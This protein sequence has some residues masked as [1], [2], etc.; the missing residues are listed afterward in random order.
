L[1]ALCL[2]CDGIYSPPDLDNNDKPKTKDILNPE[3][4]I[5]DNKKHQTFLVNLG[6]YNTELFQTKIYEFIV[7]GFFD[8]DFDNIAFKYNK[9]FERGTKQNSFREARE[10]SF[11]GSFDNNGDDVVKKIYNEFINGIEVLTPSDFQGTHRLLSDYDDGDERANKIL[12]LYFETHKDNKDM[13]E[14]PFINNQKIKDFFKESL[15]RIWNLNPP[16]LEEAVEIFIK[17]NN[18]P[19]INK[20]LN[21]VKED[22]FC[23]LFKESKI[24]NSYKLDISRKFDNA[25]L[26]IQ[27]IKK[28]SKINKLRIEYLSG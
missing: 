13:L 16:S 28:E 10:V 11:H 27:K 14:S 19:L 2:F 5:Y 26:A 18:D 8:S 21:E 24:H 12:E 7:N 9:K 17:N 22:D 1:I 15:E 25:K 20:F 23:K 3:N 6:Y 4:K